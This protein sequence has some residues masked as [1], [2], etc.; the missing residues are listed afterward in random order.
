LEDKDTGGTVKVSVLPEPPTYDIEE[1]DKQTQ[2]HSPIILPPAAATPTI[3]AVPT[4]LTIGNLPTPLTVTALPI[5]STPPPLPENST[6]KIELINP[7]PSSSTSALQP[8]PT[9]TNSVAPVTEI[10]VRSDS[11]RNGKDDKK[12]TN[13]LQQATPITNATTDVAPPVAAVTDTST[14][15]ETTRNGKD[16]KKTKSGNA[17][18]HGTHGHQ[19][20]KLNS[21]IEYSRLL[22]E[23]PEKEEKRKGKSGHI[24]IKTVI[25]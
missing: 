24:H 4:P 11:T 21:N 8:I 5:V 19:E 25:A 7:A 16:E 10:S 3:S 6:Q 20:Y 14:K 12:S 23:Y 18:L 22:V 9:S 1:L 2:N 13:T 15:S 17:E